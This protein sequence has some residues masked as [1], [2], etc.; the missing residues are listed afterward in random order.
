MDRPKTDEIAVASIRDKWST[1]PSN[2]LTPEG[3]ASIFR[4]ADG[5]DSYRQAELFEEMEEK[6]P[7]LFSC[8]QTRRLAISGVDWEVSAASEDKKDQDIA[9]FIR[10]NLENLKDFDDDL[11][12]ILDSI[13]KGISFN[14][15]IWEIKNNQIKVADL[16]WKHTKKF[17][18]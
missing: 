1:Y 7:H 13:G 8:L 5:G 6:D 2:G 11:S 15:I 10:E 4:E 3:L 18:F 16:R 9:V 12:D 17:T 14:E